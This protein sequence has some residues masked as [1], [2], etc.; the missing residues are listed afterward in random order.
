M[1]QALSW[2][3]MIS[4]ALTSCSFSDVDPE[5]DVHVSGRALDAS[6]RPLADTTVLLFKQA[7]LGEVV[8]GTV[9][10]VG[11]LSTVCL[12]PDPPAICDE[13]RTATTDGEG[14]YEFDLKGSD[15]QGTLGTESTMNVVFAGG[16]G[17]STTISFTAEEADISLPDARL[18]RANPRVAQSPGSIRLSWRGLPDAAG[19]DPS[20]SAQLYEAAGHVQWS[21]PASGGS[22]TLDPRILEER[23]GEVA[24][25]AYAALDGAD[26]AGDVRASY[27]SSRLPVRATAGVP[28]SR[29]RPCAAVTGTAPARDSAFGRCGATD[30]ELDEPARLRARGRAVVAGVAV[31]LGSARPI[32][33]VVARGFTGQVLVEASD[34][35]RSYRTIATTAGLAIAVRPQVPTTARFLRLRS[36]TGLD[37]SL[38]SEVSVW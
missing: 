25:N 10:A 11:S 26:G 32:D 2:F 18:W 4:L 12:L 1:R 6:G 17:T 23:D 16:S 13:A 37:Q 3:A 27:L 38:S 33:L 5:A 28:P 30:G 24:V 31:D 20:Y 35:G 19:D 34:D 7:D 8:F 22:A 15:T 36:P 21:E 14:R 29:G 9:L